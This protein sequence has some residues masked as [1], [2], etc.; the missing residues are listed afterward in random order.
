MKKIEEL[1]ETLSVPQL[2]I[3]GLKAIEVEAINKY[4]LSGKLQQPK[5]EDLSTS[6]IK[7]LLLIAFAPED[8]LP[9]AQR[10]A[11]RLK[12]CNSFFRFKRSNFGKQKGFP[13]KDAFDPQGEFTLTKDFD[14]LPLN[15]YSAIFQ[16]LQTKK[17]ILAPEALQSHFVTGKIGW[18][19]GIKELEI[20]APGASVNLTVEPSPLQALPEDIG[21]LIDLETL[22]IERSDISILPDSFYMLRKLKSLYLASNKLSILS[23]KIAQLEALEALDIS[24][25]QIERVPA[26]LSLLKNLKKINVSG[27]PFK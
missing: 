4:W 14:A 9:A 10:N 6:E 25:N 3:D 19:N 17:V 21:E 13:N 23:E 15:F 1:F 20:V 8:S 18:L 26:S 22:L 7:R 11:P 24:Y 12:T 5:G 2:I 16:A 27:N